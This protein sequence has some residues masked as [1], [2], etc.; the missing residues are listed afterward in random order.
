[1]SMNAGEEV[2]ISS[3]SWVRYL[4]RALLVLAGLVVVAVGGGTLGV[5][6]WAQFHYRTAETALA[7]FD[8]AKAQHHLDLYLK[9]RP[10]DSAAHFL[11]AQTARRRGNSEEA[12]RHLEIVERLQGVT[13]GTAL[14]RILQQA[15]DGELGEVEQPLLALVD[16]DDQDTA[17]IY[18][19][20][21]QCYLAGFHLPEALHCLDQL[22]ERQPDNVLGL[23]SRARIWELWNQFDK[24]LA[25][26]QR[27]VDLH[28]ELDK[29]RLGLAD[30]LSRVGRVREAVAQYDILHR[31]QPGDLEVLLRQARCW[32][33]LNELE[34]AREIADTLLTEKREWISA[35]VERGRIALR[36]RQ[37][38]QAEKWLRQAIKLAPRDRDAHFV[39]HLCL[40]CQDKKE[41][42]REVLARLND[43]QAAYH[44]RHHSLKPSGASRD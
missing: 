34:T 28:P 2:R 5:Y 41:E 4:R 18:E 10:K 9:I 3:V 1:M 35:L 33:D 40:E 7:R 11:A 36:M 19:T 16:K 25:D 30:N 29:A 39:L 22:L 27:A 13:A 37:P 26:F 38:G 14:E 42:D 12:R 8:F 20:L 6:L 31:R 23:T 21:G 17:L 44:K 43:I 15:Q 32:E 24:A